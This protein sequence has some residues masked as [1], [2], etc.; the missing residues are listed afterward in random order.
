MVKP[1]EFVETSSESEVEKEEVV[2]E[3]VAKEEAEME[4]VV[5]EEVEKVEAEKEKEA[6]QGDVDLERM[7]QIM[8]HPVKIVIAGIEFSTSEYTLMTVKEG[9]LTKMVEA[10]IFRKDGKLYVDMEALHFR[11]ILNFL[12]N[13][14]RLNGKTMPGEERFLYEIMEEAQYY[15]L[16]GLIET[17]RRRINEIK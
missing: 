1:K 15:N 4:K 14:G 8:N 17:V 16:L 11:Y 9:L 6:E 7:R 12:R 13:G 5:M 2:K 10:K 3:E